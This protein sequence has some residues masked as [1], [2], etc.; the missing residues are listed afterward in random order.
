MKALWA[1]RRH[2]GIARMPPM[3]NLSD[4]TDLIESSNSQLNQLKEGL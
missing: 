1:H 4:Y 2:R 3:V